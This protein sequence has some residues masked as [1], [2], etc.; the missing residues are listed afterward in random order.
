VDDMV[1]EGA[2]IE[3]LL[4]IVTHAV[5]AMRSRSGAAAK[6]AAAVKAELTE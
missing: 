1:M 6:P 5:A 3:E 4:G 2:T